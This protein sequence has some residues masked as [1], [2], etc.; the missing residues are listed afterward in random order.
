MVKLRR[1]HSCLTKSNQAANQEDFRKR[2]K[3]LKR[4]RR[5]KKTVYM[6]HTSKI[7]EF[8]SVPLISLCSTC[9]R[10]KV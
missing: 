9:Q 6:E 3:N 8:Q 7:F 2:L 5:Q 4:K 10:E 1:V